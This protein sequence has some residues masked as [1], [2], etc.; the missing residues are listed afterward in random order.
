M[1]DSIEAKLVPQKWVRDATGPVISLGP[2]GS[3]DDTHLFAP[4]VAYEHGTYRMW[5]CGATGNLND[6]AYKVGL[7]ESADGVHFTKDARSP[8]LVAPN[9]ADSIVTP[10][11]LRGANGAVLREDGRLRMWCI[12]ANF[13]AGT[14]TLHES[15]SI[16]GVAWTPLS[17]E[18]MR[19]I[20][21]PTVVHDGGRYRMWYTDVSRE[22][23]CFRHADSVDGIHW[24]ADPDPCMVIDQPWEHNRL[25]YP[26]VLRDGNTWLMWYGSYSVENNSRTAL[27]FAVSEDGRRWTKSPHNPML[28]PDLTRP[29]ESHYNTS[30][31]V[32]RLAD[33]SWRIWYG[34]RTKPPHVNK[35][36][37]VGTA[38]WP[39]WTSA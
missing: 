38:R 5:Y 11:L 35:Y 21:A 28:N 15:T 13:A 34:S 1:P 29:W 8:I 36:F 30:E 16:D 37:A 10:T 39:G 26:F 7:A 32:L 4:C 17:G 31:T 25:F 3:F 9:P 6:R 27:G 23:W 18:L 33:G 20:Y 12:V 22:Q 14:H 24:T 19:N 2:A